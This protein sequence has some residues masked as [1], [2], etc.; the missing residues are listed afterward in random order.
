MGKIPE[1][2]NYIIGRIICKGYLG[3]DKRHHGI[4]KSSF[5]YI[6]CGHGHRSS[7]EGHQ[8]PKIG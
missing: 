6:D 7:S 5:T 4:D 8:R 1:V 3:W 2:I